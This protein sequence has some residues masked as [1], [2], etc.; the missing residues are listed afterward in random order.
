MRKHP[1]EDLSEQEEKDK[2]KIQ[3]YLT[4]VL[5]QVRQLDGFFARDINYPF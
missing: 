5:D 3:K 2:I 4:Y 1:P